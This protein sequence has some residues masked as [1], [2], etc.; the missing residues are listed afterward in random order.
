MRLLD[1]GK[2]KEVC[3]AGRFMKVLLI[4]NAMPVY[5]HT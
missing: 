2:R 3:A 1:R 5:D 4:L